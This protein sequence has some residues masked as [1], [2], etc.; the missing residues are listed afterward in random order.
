LD[1]PGHEAARLAYQ[2]PFWRLM[3]AAVFA[4]EGQACRLDY[5]V[6]CNSVWETRSGR[7]S[8]WVGDEP[9]E[10]EIAVDASHHWYLNGEEYPQVDGCTDLDLNFSPSTNLLPIRRLGLSIGQGADVKAAWLRFPGF[11]LEPLEQRYIR[12]NDGIYRYESA[13]GSFTRELSVNEAGF[14]THYPGFWQADG[15]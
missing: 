9:V 1:Q 6:V 15:G 4:H 14:V 2:P 5:E 11:R 13:G 8:G 3:G 12:I 7:V 10:I